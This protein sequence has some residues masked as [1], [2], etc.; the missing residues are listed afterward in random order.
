MRV[1]VTG[2]SG[3]AGR[4]VV[5]DLRAHGHDVLNVDVAHD[6]SPHGQC[7]LADLTDVGQCHEVVAGADAVVHLAAIPAPGD[8]AGRPRRSATTPSRPTTCSRPRS[9]RGVERVVWASSETVLGLPFDEPPAFAPIDE[10]HPPRPETSYALSKLVGEA[11]AEQFARRPSVPVHRPPDL[12]HHGAATTTSGSSRGRT[13]RGS[14]AGTCGDTSTLGTSPRRCGE[15]SRRTSQAPEVCIVAAADTC[16]AAR[17]RRADRRG[18]PIRGAAPSHHRARDA[19]GHRPRARAAR[20][21][22]GA[23]VDRSAVTLLAASRGATVLGHRAGQARSDRS[24]LTTRSRPARSGTI[25]P[26]PSAR[27]AR[28]RP[29]PG[30]RRSRAAPSRRARRVPGG[31]RGG[32]GARRA[33]PAPPSSAIRGSNPSDPCRSSTSALATYG[34][35]AT[36]TSG[37]GRTSPA[38]ARRSAPASVTRSDTWC[39]ARFSA[40]SSSGLGRDVGGDEAQPAQHQRRSE[41]EGESNRHRAAAGRHL[42][43]DDGLRHRG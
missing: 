36:T 22:A 2:G 34:R 21:S 37:R 43:R 32:G 10:T 16:M 7:V 39:A 8:P 41:P 38:D 13:T 29:R 40:A 3:K 28:P 6:G 33:H 30:R 14:V 5:A 35:L 27:P 18:L 42:P 24:S 25:E 9:T 12:E 4:W 11:M 19:A 15:G 20:V 31:R 23:H 26:T 17:Q 1:V